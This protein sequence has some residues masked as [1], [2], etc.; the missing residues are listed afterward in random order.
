[1]DLEIYNDH[2]Y[3]LGTEKGEV[4]DFYVYQVSMDG[5]ERKKLFYLYSVEPSPMGGFTWTYDFI[6]IDGYYYGILRDQEQPYD[7]TK[8]RLD[9]EKT[10]I[11][12]MSGKSFPDIAR[13][14]GAGDYLYF[15]AQWEESDGQ[16]C[17]TLMRYNIKT[18]EIETV[19]EDFMG[20]EYCVI[21]ENHIFY[22]DISNSCYMA[23]LQSGVT[24]CV[25]EN[26]NE[27]IQA[28]FD[29]DHIYLVDMDADT[30][31][32]EICVYDTDGTAKDVIRIPPS[33]S[34]L[35][36]D[37]E[38]LFLESDAEPGT[39]QE[40]RQDDGQEYRTEYMWILDKSQIGSQ[41]KDWMKMELGQ[42][43]NS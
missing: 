27:I 30:G 37:E 36:G 15:T 29:G 22:Y 5:S 6:M 26:T 24:E 41:K 33:A 10:L 21:D 42:W 19:L 12:D 23:D 35:F 38:Y 16:T 7:L 9:G 28:S 25:V 8:I 18:D 13:L 1:M 20:S 17:Y 40:A 31:D 4:M 3:K 34:V 2:I 11:Y 39:G 32:E 14:Q 43:L